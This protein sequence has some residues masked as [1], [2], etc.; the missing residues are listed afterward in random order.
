MATPAQSSVPVLMTSVTG[1]GNSTV[2]RSMSMPVPK[3]HMDMP[4][5]LLPSA[6]AFAVDPSLQHPNSVPP[7]P[8]TP[9]S[10]AATGNVNVPS[11]ATLI[12]VS[13]VIDLH[14]YCRNAVI[15]QYT[16]F[17]PPVKEVNVLVIT[18]V[19]PGM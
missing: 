19:N 13:P 10:S 4:G 18:A 2:L 17:H 1:P 5:Q 9:R 16:S 3:H 12:R 14:A 15:S 11:C 7:H 8:P 6:S